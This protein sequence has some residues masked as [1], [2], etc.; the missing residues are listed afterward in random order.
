MQEEN[1]P[2]VIFPLR[3]MALMSS[4]SLTQKDVSIATE[5]AQSAISKYLSGK[6][7]PRATELYK[8]ATTYGI[9]IDYLLGV[10]DSETEQTQLF[11]ENLEL[12][13]K[14]RTINAALQSIYKETKKYKP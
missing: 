13:T 8:I 14:L 1:I 9:S 11:A 2:E 3:L 10:R 5:I 7:L 4:K 12:K 6:A